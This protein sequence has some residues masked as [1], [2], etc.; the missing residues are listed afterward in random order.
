MLY[1]IYLS[2]L[3]LSIIS[4]AIS[5]SIS[6]LFLALSLI[7]F[8]FLKEKPNFRTPLV[9]VLVCFYSW[10][11]ISLFYHF[12]AEGFDPLVLKRAF[13]D[14]MKDLFLL[15]AFFVIQGVKQED[16]PK[17]HRAVWYFSL[18]ILITGLVS[19]FSPIR[20]ARIV[21]DL[22]KTSTS[23]PYTQHYGN[24]SFLDI[25]LPIGLMN[26]HLTFG[27][28]VSFI[29][30]YY[31]FKVYESWK[32]EDSFR[33]IATY[34]LLFLLLAAVYLFN[35]ARSAMLG[36]IISL[37]VGFY[38]LI[39]KEKNVSLN[40]IKNASI[41]ALVGIGSIG[42]AYTQSDALKKVIKPLFGSEKHTDSGRSFIWDS[43]F[44]MIEKNPVFG[45]GPGAYQKEV[46]ITRKEKEIEHKELA[47]FYE[48]TQRGHAHNDFFHLS[49]V[50]G[51]PQVLLYILLGAM[52]L[53]GFTDNRV[54]K[55]TMYWTLG[56]TGFFFSGLLQCYF[57]DDEVLIMFY[58]LLGYY[59]IFLRKEEST[60]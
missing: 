37:L 4:C 12:C 27:G 13:R 40:M 31:F 29:F 41:I 6:Q 48:V 55:E 21:S 35:N 20:L 34:A 18:L 51:L 44:P 5:V 60:V 47:Y 17:L 57:Q 38:I 9:L 56:L 14:E 45:I 52:I 10:Q 22:Y 54:P 16:H 8:L 59:H 53:Y 25:Y 30:P 43:T 42:I 28:L 23:W 39:F 49:A 1:R 19:L 46:E 3:T 24:I 11:F 2:F 15:S 36:S 50:F 7:T 26:T 58:Y 33:K 32:N